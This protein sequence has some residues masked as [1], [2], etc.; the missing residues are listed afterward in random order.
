M[1]RPT[2]VATAPCVAP[3]LLF[4]V[5]ILLVFAIVLMGLLFVSCA[6]WKPMSVYFST[7]TRVSLSPEFGN[8]LYCASY[9]CSQ[10]WGDYKDPH[11]RCTGDVCTGI[12]CCNG[13]QWVSRDTLA[14]TLVFLGCSIATISDALLLSCGFPCV[15]CDYFRRSVVLCRR[16]S[17][18]WEAIQPFWGWG[19]FPASC[20]PF[21]VSVRAM[22]P[23]RVCALQS[24]SY[25][26]Q[27]QRPR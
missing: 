17:T 23:Q 4:A 20:P 16:D 6:Q 5:N 1:A 26:E 10:G 3:V 2:C 12:Q 13:K 27:T 9:D 21:I 25:C 11:E 7:A 14:L 19:R 24:V 8:E 15:L 18:R 22:F